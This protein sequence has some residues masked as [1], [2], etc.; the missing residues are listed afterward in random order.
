VGSDSHGPL[1]ELERTA[2]MIEDAALGHDRFLD[3]RR[4]RTP[5]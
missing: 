1:L 5:V 4:V 2:K 3:G